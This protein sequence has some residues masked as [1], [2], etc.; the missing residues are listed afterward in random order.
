MCPLDYKWITHTH[1]CK[2][3]FTSTLLIDSC[4]LS[5]LRLNLNNVE[6]AAEQAFKGLVFIKHKCKR[7]VG[8]AVVLVL[9]FYN[10]GT[11]ALNRTENQFDTL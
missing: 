4:D 11:M 9:L 8:K 3:T 10:A 6:K 7:L 2:G 5:P 1:T